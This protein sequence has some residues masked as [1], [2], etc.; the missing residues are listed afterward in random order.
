MRTTT[1][2]SVEAPE[3]APGMLEAPGLA[4]QRC[5][6]DCGRIPLIGEKVAHYAAGAMLCEL[7]RTVQTEQPVREQL[8][9]HSPEGA[10]AR[11]RVL[12]RAAA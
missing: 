10:G 2:D 8:I 11:V 7:C 5:C 6:D 1:A 9:K 4:E 12:R 3:A